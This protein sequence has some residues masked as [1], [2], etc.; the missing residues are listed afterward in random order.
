MKI[1]IV[2]AEFNHE[3]TSRMHDVAKEHAVSLNLNVIC[4]SWVPGSFD[5][6][7]VV[8]ALLRRDDVDG[9]VTLG[10]IIKGQTNHDEVIA[11]STARI[12]SELSVKYGKPVSLGVTGPGMQESLAFERIRPVAQRAVEAVLKIDGEL[13]KIRML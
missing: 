11:H 10:A 12:L 6:P 1:A 2:S 3:I 7:V 5:M 9:I 4:E 8:D 13:E